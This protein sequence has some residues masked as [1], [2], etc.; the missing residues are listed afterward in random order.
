MGLAGK[1]RTCCKSRR[2]IRAASE[3]EFD[4]D[5]NDKESSARANQTKLT[6][7]ETWPPETKISS[8]YRHH[9]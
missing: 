7:A 2:T 5:E 4:V 8:S 3:F 9:E 1:E 6:L